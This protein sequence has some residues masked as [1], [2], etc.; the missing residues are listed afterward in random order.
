MKRIILM[1]LVSVFLLFSVVAHAASPIFITRHVHVDVEDGM[2][3]AEAVT[4]ISAASFTVAEM[5]LFKKTGAEWEKLDEIAVPEISGIGYSFST[6]ASFATESLDG[7]GT[8]KISV[9]F[10]V[11]GYHEDAHSMPFQLNE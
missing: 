1:M 10:D 4:N 6:S 3:Y 2:V 9:T 7:D 8:Y 11:D 5:T